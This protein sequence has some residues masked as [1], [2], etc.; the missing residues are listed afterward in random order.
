[1]KLT[2]WLDSTGRTRQFTV[3]GGTEDHAEAWHYYYDREGR[4]RFAHAVRGAVNDTRQEERVYYAE[5]GTEVRR[6]TEVKAGPGYPF[7]PL[8]PIT[9]PSRWVRQ[10]CLRGR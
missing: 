2:V 9:D 7:G 6:I 4:L 1:M 3:Q 5:D 8:E 10:V